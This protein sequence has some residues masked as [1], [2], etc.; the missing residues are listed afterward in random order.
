VT[1]ALGLSW[2][3]WDDDFVF[4]YSPPAEDFQYTKRNVLK[5]TATLVVRSAG[6]FLPVCR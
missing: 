2:T 1:K 6:F 4:Y 3:A 5:K